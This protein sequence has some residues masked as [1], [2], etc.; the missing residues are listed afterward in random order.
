MA[1]RVHRKS[2]HYEEAALEPGEEIET[3]CRL[4]EGRQLPD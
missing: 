3:S 4:S 2:E 1:K